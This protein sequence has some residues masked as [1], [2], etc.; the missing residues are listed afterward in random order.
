M[1]LFCGLHVPEGGLR[2]LGFLVLCGQNPC[3]NNRSP[4]V[5]NLKNRCGL[6]CRSLDKWQRKCKNELPSSANPAMPRIPQIT[7]DVVEAR[8][9]Q[10]VTHVHHMG[11]FQE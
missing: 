1:L 9:F 6:K 5:E 2:K 7:Q 8:N 3:E 4:K 10:Y 11:D